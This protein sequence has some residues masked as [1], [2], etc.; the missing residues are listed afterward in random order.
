FRAVQFELHTPHAVAANASDSGGGVDAQFKGDGA[1][2]GA[3]AT[4]APYSA[5]LNTA[6]LGNG[7]HVL[8]AMARDAAGNRTTS[9]GISVTL[10]GSA[11]P[12]PS[13]G[14]LPSWIGSV[15]HN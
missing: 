11:P 9:A 12:P 1:T 6:S 5:T 8:T 14:T 3:E 7:I 13:T 10:S 4:G 15:L 2:L